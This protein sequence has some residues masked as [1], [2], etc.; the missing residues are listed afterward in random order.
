MDDDIGISDQGVDGFSI[1]NVALVVRR[2]RPPVRVR[3]EW[4]AG[5]PDDPVHGGVL[6]Q[7]CHRWI[8]ISPVGP[9]T[10][11]VSPIDLSSPRSDGVDL[12]LVIIGATDAISP[13]VR[14]RN[15]VGDVHA[16]RILPKIDHET[17]RSRAKG[18]GRSCAFNG[19]AIQRR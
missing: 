8:P 3:L 5:H 12:R 14:D 10:A 17:G 6:F 7:G 11:T 18:R 2:L 19:I 9:V 1:Q 13:D 4:P 16:A 15:S